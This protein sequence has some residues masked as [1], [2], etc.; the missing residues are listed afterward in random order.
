M[1]S[2][3]S[4]QSGKRTQ[5]NSQCH[6]TLLHTLKRHQST[7]FSVPGSPDGRMIASGSDD[8]TIRL[9]DEQWGQLLY[10]HA[11]HEDT[12]YSVA[13]SPDGSVLASGSGDDTI[14]LWDGQT[15]QHIS[16]LEGHTGTVSCVSFSSDGSLLASK[17]SDGSVR[18]WRTEPWET[19]EILK[20]ETSGA[21]LHG[22][23]FH[24][25]TPILATLGEIDTVV[26]IW[27]FDVAALLGAAP[28]TASV[29]Y[30]TA[31]IALV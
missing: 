12:I 28:A 2:N 1:E 31:K 29:R 17:S 8:R 14:R 26:R 22:I 25:H 20:E 19:L 15:G 23:A 21:V 5:N 27:D 4:E 16:T 24:P 10:T 7:I 18:I 11:G 9:W 3:E 30:T 6:L 13:W